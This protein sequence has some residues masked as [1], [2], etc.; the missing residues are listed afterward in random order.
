[1]LFT[2][3]ISVKSEEKLLF[4]G[5]MAPQVSTESVTNNSTADI[6]NNCCRFFASLLPHAAA[7][8]YKYEELDHDKYNDVKY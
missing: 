3:F 1:M 4:N 6:L 2:L 5:A 8:D 7:A